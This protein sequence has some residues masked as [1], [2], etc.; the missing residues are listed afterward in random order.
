MFKSL[1][2][3]LNALLFTQTFALLFLTMTFLFAF[4]SYFHPEN[5]NIILYKITLVFFAG[6]AGFWLDNAVFPF[7][8]PIDYENMYSQ[9]CSGIDAVAVEDGD[10]NCE[11][12]EY[13]SSAKLK[14]F[15]MYL[16]LFIPA[17]Y[18]RAFIIGVCIIGVCLGL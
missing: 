9:T 18:R 12:K 1:R 13:A 8:R 4:L 16:K 7:A 2:L 10:S 15:D 17:C 14:A 3:F 6:F 11:I 5:V